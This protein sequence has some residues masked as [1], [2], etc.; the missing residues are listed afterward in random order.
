MLQLKISLYDILNFI[1]EALHESIC[2]LTN[3]PSMSLSQ[4]LC[5]LDMRSVTSISH[6]MYLFA[7]L[8]LFCFLGLYKSAYTT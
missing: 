7:C 4:A 1:K 8:L 6:L 3:I 5:F 2:N